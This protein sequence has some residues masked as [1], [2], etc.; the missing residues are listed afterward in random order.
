MTDTPEYREDKFL[1]ENKILLISYAV[2]FILM[3]PIIL[4]RDFTPNNE[5]RY[6]SIADEALRNG[7]WFSFYNHGIPYADKPPLYFWIIMVGKKLFGYHLPFFLMLFSIIPAFITMHIMNKW[8]RNEMPADCRFMA[9]MQLGATGMFIICTVLLRMDM[10]MCMFIVLSLY[11]FYEIYAG[12]SSKFDEWL[13]PL[14]IFLGVFTKGPIGILIPV[15]SILSFLIY[16]KQSKQISKFFGLKSLI[17]W[18]VC[19]GFWFLNVYI[20]AD[21][22]YLNNLLFNQTINRGFDAFHHKEPFYYYLGTM[23]YIFAPWVIFYL[24]AIFTG[25]RRKVFDSDKDRLF[26][27]II[28]VSFLLLSVISSKLDI[29]M[30]PLIPFVAY[31]SAKAAFKSEHS[32]ILTW[33]MLITALLFIVIFSAAIIFYDKF[34]ALIPLS[35]YLYKYIVIASAIPVVSGIIA[36]IIFYKR[37]TVTHSCIVLSLGLLLCM[38]VLGTQIDNINQFIGYKKAAEK[39]KKLS[40]SST[41]LSYMHYGLSE[42]ENIDVYVGKPVPLANRDEILA[43]R[44]EGC[45]LFIK[46]KSVDR[47]IELGQY[48]RDKQIYEVGNIYVIHLETENKK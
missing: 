1:S 11:T 24:I 22:S 5:L 34:A 10:L 17:V 41:E 48:L 20:E 42:G 14:Y 23:W 45:I 8:T 19:F 7:N 27:T 30:L 4:L 9:K 31:L 44:L 39:A 38:S 3:L 21:S 37:K 29:Y 43:D 13:L 36:I 6:L 18:V 33:G 2:I 26:I 47:D 25:I 15:L 35:D 28:V 16:K 12:K 40:S 32:T 46:K